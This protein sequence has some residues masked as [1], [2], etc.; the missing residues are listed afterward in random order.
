ME[1]Q[2]SGFSNDQIRAYMNE[3]HQNAMATTARA[4]KEHF[5][6]ERIAE[7]EK[8]EAQDEDFEKEIELI[9]DQADETP[10]RVRA[11][12]E[13]KGLMDTLRNQVIER[14]V[15][16]LIEQH[17]EFRDVA[18]KPPHDETV[19]VA[20]AAAGA[21]PESIPAAEHDEGI[22]PATAGKTKE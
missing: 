14:K 13:K 11:R 8:I 5:I 1:L 6:L 21:S 19:A 3:L 2:S 12:L 17:A 15:I 20:Y 18:Y 4:L 7:E 16:E 10:R 9:A 22:N